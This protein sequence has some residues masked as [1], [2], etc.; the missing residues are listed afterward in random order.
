[1]SVCDGFTIETYWFMHSL[2]AFLACA[3]QDTI[4]MEVEVENSEDRK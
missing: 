2:R 1:M 3:T 4:V